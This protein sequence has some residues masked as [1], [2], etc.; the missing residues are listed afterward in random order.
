MQ[1]RDFKD[2]MNV[3]NENVTAKIQ[4]YV[5]DLMKN[6]GKNLLEIGPPITDLDY[7]RTVIY[8]LLHKLVD[9]FKPRNDTYE[10]IMH[11]IFKQL[12]VDEPSRPQKKKP[13]RPT[14]SRLHKAKKQATYSARNEDSA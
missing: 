3:M 5:S 4:E 13:Q 14:K 7:S 9:E 2:A 12:E 6:G 8:A 11:E 10:H 1:K